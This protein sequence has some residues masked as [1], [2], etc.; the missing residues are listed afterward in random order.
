[1]MTW[2]GIAA[3]KA[4]QNHGATKITEKTI[5]NEARKSGKHVYEKDI[6]TAVAGF[7]ASCLISARLRD[8]RGSVVL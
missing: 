3:T 6:Y 2:R 8:L 5:D 7:Q 1:M 4:E